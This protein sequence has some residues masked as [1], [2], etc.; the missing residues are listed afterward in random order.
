VLTRNPLRVV[1]RERARIHG[2]DF[3]RIK[4]LVRGIGRVDRECDGLNGAG[5]ARM[6]ESIGM[7][8]LLQGLDCSLTTY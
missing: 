7:G 5:T 6:S 3:P 4:E 2:N 1:E 8:I